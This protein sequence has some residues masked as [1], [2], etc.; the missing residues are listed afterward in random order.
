[1]RLNIFIRL[2]GSHR[3][4]LEPSVSNIYQSRQPMDISAQKVEPQQR[5]FRMNEMRRHFVHFAKF[6]RAGA[7]KMNENGR[8][9]GGDTDTDGGGF[10]PSRSTD[11]HRSTDFL[12]DAT[13]NSPITSSSEGALC[14]RQMKLRHFARV[15]FE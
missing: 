10:W 9:R 3:N 11:D 15:N 6:R 14:Q 12:S 5:P 2:V 13:V 4:R 8:V 1:M 7:G